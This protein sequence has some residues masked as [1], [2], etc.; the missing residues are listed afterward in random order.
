MDELVYLLEEKYNY[1]NLNE[2]GDKVLVTLRVPCNHKVK[3]FLLKHG[4][5]NAQQLIEKKFVSRLEKQ[6]IKY[7]KRKYGS[8]FDISYNPEGKVNWENVLQDFSE[9][10]DS[11]DEYLKD[12]MNDTH[13]NNWDNMLKIELTLEVE[14]MAFYASMK[15][16]IKSV[17]FSVSDHLS[18][19]INL[20]E[21]VSLDNALLYALNQFSLLN[22]MLKR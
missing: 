16:S 8:A 14:D 17:D 21:G 18:E 1:D 7:M 22:L 12:V 11:I 10:W 19:G 20:A 9:G 13:E 2:D 4:N 6:V 5:E 3:S 15:A